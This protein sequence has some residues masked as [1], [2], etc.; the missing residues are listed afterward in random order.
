M[1][2]VWSIAGSDNSCGAGVQGDNATF[3]SFDVLAGNIITAVTA[4]N[5]R[6]VSSIHNISKTVFDRQWVALAQEYPAK[7]IKLG[8]LSN[9]DIFAAVKD[10]L[11][12]FSGKVVCDPVLAS[13]S[14]SALTSSASDYISLLPF[15]DVLTPNQQEFRQLFSLEFYNAEQL[16]EHALHIAN[17]YQ[18]DLVITGGESSITQTASDLCIINGKHYW[19]HGEKVQSQNTHGTGCSFSSAI[20]ACLARGLALLDACVLAK[21]YLTQGL[22]ADIKLAQNPAPFIHTGFPKNLAVLPTLA[23]SDQPFVLQ[24]PATADKLGLYPVVDSIE[25]LEKCLAAGV[26][27]IQLRVKDKTTE[28]LDQLVA[29]AAELGRQF[30]ARLFINDYWKL[31]IKHKAYGVHLGQE[32]LDSA[33]VAAI[34][35]AGLRLG[36]STHSWYEIARAHYYRPSYI[37]IGPIFETTTKQMP[38]DPQGVTQLTQWLNFIDDQYPTVA[39][40]GIDKSNAAAVL[41]SGVGSIAMVRAIT[42]ADNYQQ[43]ISDLQALIA[44]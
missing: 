42:E 11:Q 23:K 44:A 16:I 35:Q 18:L 28:K 1:P 33:D 24:A 17:M 9:G 25:W 8:M 6:G 38:F 32:D 41:E 34:Y 4:Q 10:K 43:A 40:G 2:T 31:A 22:K 27:T 20:A 21:A 13:S 15:I 29:K 26:K 39:I 7:V 3:R 14:G 37:A 19:L 36:I 5:S 30:E 12:I